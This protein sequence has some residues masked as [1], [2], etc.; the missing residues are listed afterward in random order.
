[1]F[2]LRLKPQA[3]WV[4]EMVIRLHEPAVGSLAPEDGEPVAEEGAFE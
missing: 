2:A 4:G 1:M 3:A